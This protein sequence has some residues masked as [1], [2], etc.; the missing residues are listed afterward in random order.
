MGGS[1]SPES[2]SPS[3]QGHRAGFFGLT[4]YRRLTDLQNSVQ[5]AG[6]SSAI[7]PCSRHP[8]REAVLTEPKSPRAPS[9]CSPQRSHSPAFCS[10]EM[11]YAC[12]SIVYK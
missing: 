11:G 12:F 9:S 10:L 1:G 3:S 6:C 8:D 4:V 7:H 2:A 5:V